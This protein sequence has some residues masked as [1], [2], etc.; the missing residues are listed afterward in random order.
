MAAQRRLEGSERR[1]SVAALDVKDKRKML[2]EFKKPID[3]TSAVR[4]LR[5]CGGGPPL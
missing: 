1:V 3:D 5:S 2:D 4:V